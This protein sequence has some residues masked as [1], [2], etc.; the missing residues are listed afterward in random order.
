MKALTSK[1]LKGDVRA[2]TAAIALKRQV[3]EEKSGV[4]AEAP[5]TLDEETLMEL[6]LER[7]KRQKK[8][9]KEGSDGDK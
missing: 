7:A 1:A 3:H 4:T 9:R 2:L 6:L 5:L 8:T